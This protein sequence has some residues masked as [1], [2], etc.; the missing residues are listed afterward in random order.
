MPQRL[1]LRWGTGGSAQDRT[2]VRMIIANCLIHCH[3]Q[4]QD[5][6]LT[7]ETAKQFAR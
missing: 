5:I 7:K 6:T 3:R 1:K 4:F 2:E